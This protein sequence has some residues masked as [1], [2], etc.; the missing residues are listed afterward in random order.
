M[1]VRA[2]FVLQHHWWRGQIV[3]RGQP[4]SHW[5]LRLWEEK[6]PFRYWNL[7]KDPTYS[8]SNI[9]AIEKKCE[10]KRYIAFDGIIP[11]HE[12]APDWLKPANPNKRIPAF[13]D[14][15]DK[16]IVHIIE[17]S[18]MFI[19]F[20]F[21]GKDLKGYWVMRKTMPEELAWIFEKSKFPRPKKMTDERFLKR[22]PDWKINKIIEMTKSE[23][24]S[25]PEIAKEANCSKSTVYLYQEMAKK[26][27]LI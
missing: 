25:R 6:L 17:D 2:Q 4:V 14:I 10:E 13:I 8:Q 3:I 5:D 24:F 9:V 27:G 18:P 16:G 26:K 19:S 22:I 7:D 1:T 11:P 21:Q 23:K 12:K 15:I 20:V